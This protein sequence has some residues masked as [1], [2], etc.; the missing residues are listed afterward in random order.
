ML[1]ARV[2]YRRRNGKGERVLDLV[3]GDDYG[4]TSDVAHEFLLFAMTAAQKPVVFDA[5]GR[6]YR[7]PR[8]RLTS[9]VVW[10]DDKA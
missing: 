9:L 2:T 5:H 6:Y 1:R 4:L 3:L 8:P 10:V 7:V